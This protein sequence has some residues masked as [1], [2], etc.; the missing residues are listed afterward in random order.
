[1]TLPHLTRTEIIQRLGPS[2][3]AAHGARVECVSR[4]G[5]GPWQSDDLVFHTQSG[6]EIPATFVHPP[7]DTAPVPAVLYCHAHGANYPVGRTEL[8][9]GRKALVGPYLGD[10]IRLGYA[11]L[12]VEMPCF[13]ARQDLDESTLAKAALWRGDTLF[14]QMLGELMMGL[15]FLSDHPQI[16]PARI[17]T[18]GLSMGGTHAWWLAALDPRIKAAASLCCLADLARLIESGAHDGHGQYMT[19]P[20]LVAT[21]STGRLAGLTA[22]RAQLVCVGLQDWSTP[23][24]AFEQARV[25]LEASYAAIGASDALEF[26]VDPDLG[27]EETPQMRAC[28]LDFLTRRL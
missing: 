20:G 22:P 18:L 3:C 9:D 11:V 7:A 15:D 17:A 24:P 16:D 5:V 26:F 1:M 27:H 2:F 25:D 12:C 6:A 14:G 21:I 4:T 23:K 10:L 8:T 28:V 19:V 13:G